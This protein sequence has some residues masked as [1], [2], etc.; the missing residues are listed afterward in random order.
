VRERIADAFLHNDERN[1]WS[2]IKCIRSCKA[3][4]S[5]IIDGQTDVGDIARLFA[6]KYRELYTSV[7]YDES[8][9]QAL[10]EDLNSTLANTPVID[11]CMFNLNEIKAAIS[12]L[13]AHK[14]EGSSALTSD[15]VINA[16]DDYCIHIGR[17]FTALVV[18]GV[19]AD[20]FLYST[21]V[22]IPKGHS[23]NSSDSGN[24]RGIALSSIYVKIFD[25]I[26]LH[27]YHD[28]LAS[29]DLQFGFK[30]KSSTNMCSVVLKEAINYYT[31]HRSS[32]F[33]TFLDASKAFDRLHYYKLFRL[34]QQRELPA[35]VIRLLVNL[36][37]R[38]LVRVSWHGMLSDYFSAV[39]GVKQGAVLS[40]VLFCVYID[41]LLT[42]LSRSGV[43]CFIG[44]YFVGDW[45]MQMI[46]Y[47]LH[48]RQQPCVNC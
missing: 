48:R 9:M 22:P 34:L 12:Q 14:S 17:L 40:P 13:K 8:E 33:C 35:H 25:N 18:H 37:T 36:Y 44:S 16:A 31:Q 1:F 30:P 47:S 27:R 5:R 39:N 29:C 10:I 15:H 23:A 26:I 28:S 4:S 43:G 32:V 19:V 24:F 7:A 38:N 11:D 20:S 41:N 2:E 6:D 42:E 21:I 45:L 46:S 3:G